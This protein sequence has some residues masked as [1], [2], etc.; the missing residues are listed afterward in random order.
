MKAKCIVCGRALV[1]IGNA[2]EN[3]VSHHDDWV[4][5]QYHKKCLKDLN[6]HKSYFSVPYKRKEYAKSLGAR[7]DP[8][9]RHWYSPNDAVYENVFNDFAWVDI[10]ELDNAAALI[11]RYYKW[12]KCVCK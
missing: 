1:A 10:D 5:R 3:G 12:H 9:V 2:R 6:W 8:R 7:W 4:T 11:Q